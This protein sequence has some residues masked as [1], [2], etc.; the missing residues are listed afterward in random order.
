M[1]KNPGTVNQ[2]VIYPMT[3]VAYGF[4]AGEILPTLTQ[5]QHQWKI[6]HEPRMYF[7]SR[8]RFQASRKKTCQIGNLPPER[9]RP[10]ESSPNREEHRLQFWFSLSP[11]VWNSR[12][13]SQPT[14]LRFL[15]MTSWDPRN[16]LGMPPVGPNASAF[17]VR[18]HPG[19][20]DIG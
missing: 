1:E 14:T 2:L 11:P 7:L 17:K 18:W 12:W 16:H 8:W 15:N 19:P 13:I 4:S 6:H 5:M 20:V 10:W 3:R 9:V